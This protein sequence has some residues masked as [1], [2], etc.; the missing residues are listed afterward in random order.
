MTAR[1]LRIIAAV[2]VGLVLL[3]VV[4]QSVDDSDT[5]P[6]GG[7]LLPAFAGVANDVHEVRIVGPDEPDGVTLQQVGD[8]WVVVERDNYPADLGKLRQLV[9]ALSEASIVEE[10]TSNPEYYDRLGLVDPADGGSGLRVTAGGEDFSST[11][12]FGETAQGEHRYARNPEQPT[13]YLVDR[14]PAAP[15]SPGEW[16]DPVIVDIPATDVRLV[17]IEHAD[18]ETVE[19]ARPDDAEQPDFVPVELPE[20]RELSYPS[21]AN[22]IAG[23]LANLELDDVRPATERAAAGEARFE[24]ASGLVVNVEVVE[25]ADESESTGAPEDIDA[26]EDSDDSEAPVETTETWLRFT[27]SAGEES[28]DDAGAAAKVI[29]ERTNGWEYRVPD[30]KIQLLT[31]RW[32][33][34]LKAL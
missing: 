27:A 26:A 11:V 19:L 22:G 2:T 17:T 30:Y 29:N 13:S 23:A 16:L 5:R 9:I 21:V 25:I 32:D 4:L 33:D 20:G 7:K 12:I 8:R 3:L 34:L 24:T 6:T 1:S 31:K 10:K 28:G 14:D 15:A 18:G